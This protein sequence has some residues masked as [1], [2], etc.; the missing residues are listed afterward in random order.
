MSVNLRL[1]A[2]LEAAHVRQPDVQDR[3]RMRTATQLL[4]P[5]CPACSI[6]PITFDL[7]A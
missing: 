5:R 4:H 6:A 2:D 1:A 7:S 3:Q